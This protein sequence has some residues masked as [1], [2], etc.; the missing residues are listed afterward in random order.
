MSLTKI[1]RTRRTFSPCRPG[2][3]PRHHAHQPTRQPRKIQHAHLTNAHPYEPGS[4]TNRVM[5]LSRRVSAAGDDVVDG[6]P[7]AAGVVGVSA[8]PPGVVGGG[9]RAAVIAAGPVACRRPRWLG[10]AVSVRV[11]A[12]RPGG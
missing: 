8:E 12:A 5:W 2:N 4:F 3:R 10:G 1:G 9:A 7:R 11:V 6:E